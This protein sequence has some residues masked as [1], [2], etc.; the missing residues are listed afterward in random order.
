MEM[1]TCKNSIQRK[2]CSE[3]LQITECSIA[4]CTSVTLEKAFFHDSYKAS[5]DVFY[6]ILM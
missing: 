2:A 1:V 6:M 4:V 5:A 3:I